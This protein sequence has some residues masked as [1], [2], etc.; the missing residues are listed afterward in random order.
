MHVVYVVYFGNE[1]KMYSHSFQSEAEAKFFANAIWE[2]YEIVS[3]MK[4]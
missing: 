4:E 2:E 3:V 1:R